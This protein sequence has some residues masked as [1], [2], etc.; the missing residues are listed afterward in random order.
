MQ[1]S[2][3]LLTGY[4]TAKKMYKVSKNMN[5]PDHLTEVPCGVCPVISQC[6]EGGVISPITCVYLTQWLD[7][8]PEDSKNISSLISW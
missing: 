1:S 3:L 7:M 5:P 8:S 4:A 2:V 6:T